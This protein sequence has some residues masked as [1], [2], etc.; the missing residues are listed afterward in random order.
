[1]GAGG[2]GIKTKL[3]PRWVKVSWPAWDEHGNMTTQ[4]GCHKNADVTT[5]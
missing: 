4:S 2:M 3:R 5:S 1:M